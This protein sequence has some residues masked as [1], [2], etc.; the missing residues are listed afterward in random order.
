MESLKTS[1]YRGYQ[2]PGSQEDEEDMYPLYVH[3]FLFSACFCGLMSF[4][5]FFL[6]P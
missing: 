4:L 6:P 5:F 2:W 1:D 3:V